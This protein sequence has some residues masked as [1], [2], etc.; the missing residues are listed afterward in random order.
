MSREI[1][2]WQKTGLA[3]GTSV[4][5]RYLD[6]FGLTADS[7]AGKTVCD[8]GCGPLAGM[9]SVLTGVGRG[10][11]VDVLAHTY[12]EWGKT[13]IPIIWVDPYDCRTSLLHGTCDAIFCLNVLDHTPVPYA[14]QVEMARIAKPGAKVYLHCHIRQ[15]TKAHYPLSDRRVKQIF[16]EPTWRAGWWKVAKDDINDQPSLMAIAAVLERGTT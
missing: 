2:Y 7:F 16:S 1:K 8:F 4:Y 15:K 3:V 13:P 10:L 11:P 12:N 5:L 6:L 14:M 9:L